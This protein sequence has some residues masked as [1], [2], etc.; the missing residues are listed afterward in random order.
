MINQHQRRRGKR[1]ICTSQ[2]FR[3]D[4][5]WHSISPQASGETSYNRTLGPR[6]RELIHLLEREIRR[7]MQLVLS[8]LS[9]APEFP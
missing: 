7:V 4:L 2:I 5:V 9:G 8:S 1:R 3:C 6:R